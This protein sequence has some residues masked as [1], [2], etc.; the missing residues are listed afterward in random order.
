MGWLLSPSSARSL[1]GGA[2]GGHAHRVPLR[3]LGC[4]G[5]VFH[6]SPV[7]Q[8]FAFR[9]DCLFALPP[10]HPSP[11][12]GEL[13]ARIGTP[14]LSLRKDHSWPPRAM[15]VPAPPFRKTTAAESTPVG[16]HLPRS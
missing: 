5:G 7:R 9:V 6:C 2:C 12:P 11:D 3:E 15:P 8:Q 10:A 14:S 13:C 4:C 1:D 16:C